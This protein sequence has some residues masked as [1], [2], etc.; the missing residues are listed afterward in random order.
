VTALPA[1]GRL[2]D[3]RPLEDLKVIAAAPHALASRVTRVSTTAAHGVV[4]TF[5]RG[6]VAYFGGTDALPDKWA[7]LATVLAYPA[8]SGASYID[9]SV[10]RHPAAGG[11][12]DAAGAQSDTPQITTTTPS[13]STSQP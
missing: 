10:A 11:V 2:T 7:A 12:A 9:V 13:T 4:V 6:P 3:A 8:S 1:G 5:R